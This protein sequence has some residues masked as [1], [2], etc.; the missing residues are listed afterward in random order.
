MDEATTTSSSLKLISKFQASLSDLESADCF[1]KLWFN[2]RNELKKLG[3]EL[4]TLLTDPLTRIEIQAEGNLLP[5]VKNM[6][7]PEV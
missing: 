1:S 5:Y 3:C 6:L 2:A 7:I 4:S